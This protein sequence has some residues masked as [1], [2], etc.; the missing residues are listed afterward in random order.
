MIDLKTEPSYPLVGLIGKKRVGK[1]SFARRLTES[2]GYRRHS[3]AELL[4]ESLLNLDPIVGATGRTE[5]D[6]GYGG[7]LYPYAEAEVIHL[8][9]TVSQHGWEGAKSE[10]EVRRLMQHYGH[11][12]RQVD[13]D[14]WVRPVMHAIATSNAPAVITD[15]RYLNEAEAVRAKGGV[16]VR[17]VRPGADDGDTHPSEVELDGY[18][19]TFEVVNE[20][21]IEHLWELVD[22]LVPALNR[23]RLELVRGQ[24]AAYA[25]AYDRANG[26]RSSFE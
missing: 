1:D 14:F 2:H 9:D 17:I 6:Y 13:P 26:V 15:V 22:N 10:P 24:L 19:T 25:W 5:Y 11:G 12:I 21:G 8:S 16:L 18:P 3:F 4:R 20:A 7:E 23:H